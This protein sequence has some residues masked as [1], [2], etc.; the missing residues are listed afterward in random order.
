[1]KKFDSEMKEKWLQALRSGDYKKGNSYLC[2]KNLTKKGFSYCC[3]GVLAEIN[4]HLYFR[5]E[6]CGVNEWPYKTTNMNDD[7]DWAETTLIMTNKG[8][9]GYIMYGIS[10]KDHS[11]L[12][13]IN[14][15]AE[16]FGEAIHYIEENM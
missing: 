8:K 7:E 13:E 9:S 5:K 11:N 10:G 12:I 14:D 16:T 6:E 2:R 1:M 3:L 15:N 4:G